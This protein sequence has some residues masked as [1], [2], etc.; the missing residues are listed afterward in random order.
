M[1]CILSVRSS[2]GIR[3]SLLLVVKTNAA[4]NI[5]VQGVLC[6]HNFLSLGHV[7]LTMGCLGHVAT[8]LHILRNLNATCHSS[9][10]HAYR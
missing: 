4:V 3:L 1:V 6:T 5:L 9:S 10:L 2:A 8:L 7:H